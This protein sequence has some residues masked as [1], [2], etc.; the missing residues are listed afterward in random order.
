MSDFPEQEKTNLQNEE[1]FSTIFS[2]PTAHKK[3]AEDVKKKKLL[4]II[5]AA[6]LAVAVLVGGTVGVVKLIPEKEYRINK[7]S[8]INY[9]N[10]I[11]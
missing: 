8:F 11:T 5:I 1:E 7:L 4:P 9:S 10:S 6:F 3:T 2:D